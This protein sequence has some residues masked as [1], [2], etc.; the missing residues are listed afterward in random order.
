MA[1]KLKQEIL[2]R[3]CARYYKIFSFA[4]FN[5]H[6]LNTTEK[7]FLSKRLNFAIP[8]THT[9]YADFMLPFELLYR[10]VESLEVSN[11]DKEFIKSRFR[12]SAFS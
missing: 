5:F 4:I 7:S 10:D 6:V 3:L 2:I 11:L 12:H 9:N 1:T 8:P